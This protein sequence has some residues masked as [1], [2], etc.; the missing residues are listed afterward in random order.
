MKKPMGGINMYKKL[1]LLS[2]AIAIAIGAAFAVHETG[3][4]LT[5][6]ISEMNATVDY[7]I[8]VCNDGDTMINEVRIFENTRYEDFACQPVSGWGDVMITG[9]PD[10]EEGSVDFCWY[11][12]GED[13]AMLPGECKMFRFSARTPEEG[14]DFEWRVDTRNLD[15]SGK[16]SI[17]TLYDTTNGWGCE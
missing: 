12:T 10:E 17:V 11:F 15:G 14:C 2:L 8:N 7:E 3:V 13:D 9:Y 4:S 1:M 6:E 5:P 16:G